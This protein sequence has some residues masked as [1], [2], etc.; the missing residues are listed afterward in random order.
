MS[1]FEILGMVF[2]TVGLTLG[3][4]GLIFQR[5]RPPEDQRAGSPRGQ[6]GSTEGLKGVWPQAAG[7]TMQ[8]CT[9]SPKCRPTR[10]T[11]YAG[12][13]LAGSRS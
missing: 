3:T 6:G 8:G 9:A 11:G 5:H 4:L 1:T 10:P 2:G 13:L 12:L 7:E